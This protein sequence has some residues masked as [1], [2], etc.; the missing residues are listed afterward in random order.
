MYYINDMLVS[1][2]NTKDLL[3]AENTNI[4]NHN[5]DLNLNEVILFIK[6]KINIE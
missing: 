5:N 4:D 2:T 6:Y 1:E 3:Y